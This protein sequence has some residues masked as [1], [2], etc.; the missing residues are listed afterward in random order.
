MYQNEQRHRNKMQI[1]FAFFNSNR[2][3]LSDKN[4]IKQSRALVFVQF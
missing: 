3:L 1:F 4:E 2:H